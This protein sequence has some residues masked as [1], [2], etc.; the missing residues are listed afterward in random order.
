MHTGRQADY[1]TDEDLEQFASGDDLAK[2]YDLVIFSGHEEYV[3]QQIY[4]V[5]QRYRDLGGNLAFLSANNFFRHV[6]LSKN[7]LWRGRLWRDV[8]RPESALIGVQYNGNDR[9]GHVAP[10]M[11]AQPEAAPWLFSGIPVAAGMPALS[12]A[13]RHRVDAA[14]SFSPPGTSCWRRSHRDYEAP[15]SA[16]R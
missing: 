13:L 1:L 4:D 15:R 12:C 9:G 14:T 2:L 8:G 7:H 6:V 16:G 5:V 10:Y 3:T 11:V